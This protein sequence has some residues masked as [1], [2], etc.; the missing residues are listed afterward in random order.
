MGNKGGTKHLKRMA[1]P[2]F[3]PIHVKE[4]KWVTKPRPGSHPERRSL[5][6]MTI[7]RDVLKIARTGHEG[8]LIISRGAMNVDG[9]PRKDWRY[10]A[11]LMDTVELQ[12]I[13]AN[14]R[15]LPV[16]GRRL[17][18]VKIGQDESRYK[19]CKIIDKTTLMGGRVQLNL[20]DGRNIQMGAQE[21]KADVY[22]TG[23]SLQISLPD[24][25]ILGHLKLEK[26]AYAII[27]DGKNLG[28]SGKVVQLEEKEALITVESPDG[29]K[30]QSTR[31]YVMVVGRDQP[32]VKL[33]E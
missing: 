18:L 2:R 7:I 19:L 13:K 8:R 4:R 31:D 5:P 9:W 33:G 12:G 30:L 1:A 27:T 6:L 23:D 26:G 3:W 29:Q 22:R 15:I 14:Y 21:G 17:S 11:G 10:P 25:K 16:E 20:H 28:R 24:Q 32:L